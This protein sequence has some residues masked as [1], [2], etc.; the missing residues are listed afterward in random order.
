MPGHNLAF[1]LNP[2]DARIVVGYF[3]EFDPVNS[4]LR[5]SW[6]GN[7]IDEALMEAGDVWKKM[8]GS[9]TSMQVALRRAKRCR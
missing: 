1:K 2:V 5:Y 7:L 9:A 8:V 3:F 6:E 4:V